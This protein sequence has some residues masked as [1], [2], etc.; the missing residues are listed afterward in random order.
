MKVG[1]E[2]ILLNPDS[3]WLST[4]FKVI[5]VGGENC[6]VEFRRNGEKERL[7]VSMDDIIRVWTEGRIVFTNPDVKCLDTEEVFNSL[8]E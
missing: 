1:T 3:K 6:F 2:F 7:E 5:D 4:G 8:Y